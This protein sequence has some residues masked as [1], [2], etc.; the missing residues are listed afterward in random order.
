[1]LLRLVT[2][3][4]ALCALAGVLLMVTAHEFEV[5]LYLG[6]FGAVELLA[7]GLHRFAVAEARLPKFQRRVLNLHGD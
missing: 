2:I 5:A 6:L 1:M 3:F 7:V 4:A